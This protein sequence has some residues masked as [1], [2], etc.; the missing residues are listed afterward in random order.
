MGI[1]GTKPQ[2]KGEKGAKPKGDRALE[3]RE[4]AERVE[5]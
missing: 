4:R 3:G 5:E 1:S 2:A